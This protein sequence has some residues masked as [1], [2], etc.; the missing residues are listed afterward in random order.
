MRHEAASALAMWRYYREQRAPY[1]ALSVYL[2]A[3]H[4]GKVRTVVR[5]TTLAADDVFGVT[6]QPDALEF[7]GKAWPLDFGVAADGA[8][9]DWG[10]RE[11]V[12]SDHGW[13]GLVADLLGPWQNRRKTRRAPEQ[14]RR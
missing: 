11:F 8:A 3:A 1:P 13:T 9:G 12:V 2:A 14:F 7:D 6:R 4:H 5:A 10:E